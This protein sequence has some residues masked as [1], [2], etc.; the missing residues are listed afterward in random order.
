M[1]KNA[2]RLSSADP[3]AG[4]EAVGTQAAEGEGKRPAHR[5]IPTRS[6]ALNLLSFLA[7]LIVMKLAK[8]LMVDL[9]LSLFFY[10]LL[11]PLVLFLCRLGIPR[12][13]AAGGTVALALGLLITAAFYSVEPAGRWMEEIPELVPTLQAKLLPVSE[14]I[15]KI[16]QAA[17]EVESITQPD[18]GSEP[19]VTLSRSTSIVEDLLSHA[20]TLLIST[21]VVV[22]LTF[23]FLTFGERLQ[24]KVARL[25]RSL[26]EQRRLVTIARSIQS[27]ISRFLGI[28]AAINLVL[29]A[30]SSFV[31][32]ALGVPNYLLWG[33]LAGL[34][35][36]VPYAGAAAMTV[37]LSAV[38]LVTFDTLGH[39]A[40]VPAAF[41][42]LTILEGQLIT[43]MLVG[44]RLNLS[45]AIVLFAV[46]FWAYMWGLVGALV[47]VPILVST[48]IV[49]S[50]VPSLKPMAPLFR[51]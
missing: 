35:N 6:F 42:V 17:S 18:S 22:F 49:F 5:P 11:M 15:A 39:A 48:K 47:A 36:F 43:P 51:R 27:E 1:N 44:R 9:A 10:F 4:L 19:T 45:P 12:A 46:I 2:R 28:I 32:W 13:L 29:A 50:Y 37:L 24:Q 8:P 26:G 14:P 21:G 25:G 31:F 34:A 41:L 30:V 23:F 20:A 3:A 33:G 16:E 38:G 40:L 7:V